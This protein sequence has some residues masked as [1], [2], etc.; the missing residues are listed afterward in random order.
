MLFISDEVLTDLQEQVSLARLNDVEKI[1]V[2]V[3]VL[4]NL[5]DAYE[6]AENKMLLELDTPIENSGE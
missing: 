5:L 2:E 1:L 4:T 3:A 6:V